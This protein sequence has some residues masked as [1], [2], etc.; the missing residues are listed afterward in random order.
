[1]VKTI[2]C[3]KET[4]DLLYGEIRLRNPGGNPIKEI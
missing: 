1:M 4:F 3:D 2:Q